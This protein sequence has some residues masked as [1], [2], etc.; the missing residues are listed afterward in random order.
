M[1][2]INRNR[3]DDPSA[4]PSVVRRASDDFDMHAVSAEVTVETNLC[5]STTHRV[6]DVG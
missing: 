6:L 1:F 3:N 2:L 4:S 5:N